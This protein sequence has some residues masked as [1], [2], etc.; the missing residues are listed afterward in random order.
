MPERMSCS[1]FSSLLQRM[2]GSSRESFLRASS[3]LSL[4][5]RVYGSMAMKATA[6]GVS[7][8]LMRRFLKASGGE[9]PW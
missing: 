2:L 7:R 8:A 6:G 3:S 5:V 9:L 1:V 4:A